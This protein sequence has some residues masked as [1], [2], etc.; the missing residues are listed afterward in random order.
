MGEAKLRGGRTTSRSI[1]AAIV[2]RRHHRVVIPAAPIVLPAAAGSV[3]HAVYPH[4]LVDVLDLLLA[5]EFE[6]DRELLLDVIVDSARDHHPTGL[7]QSFQSGRDVDAVAIKVTAFGDHV[8]EIDAYA[9]D[10]AAVVRYAIIRRNH[11]FL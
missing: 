10:H 3:K 7:G 11:A 4:G 5:L 2:G 8:T 6:P 9:E 1:P